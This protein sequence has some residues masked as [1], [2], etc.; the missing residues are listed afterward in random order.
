MDACLPSD[1]RCASLGIEENLFCFRVVNPVTPLMRKNDD[2][3]RKN[4]E[5]FLNVASDVI[6]DDD[7]Q[8]NKCQREKK[9]E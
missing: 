6:E 4:S 3:G 9:L 7:E 8:R 5:D 1:S 2:A